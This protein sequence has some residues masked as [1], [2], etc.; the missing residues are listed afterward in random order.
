MNSSPIASY[1]IYRLTKKC[2][3]E[4]EGID[5]GHSVCLK[6]KSLY[7]NK[8]SEN[9]SLGFLEVLKL[10][11]RNWI[12]LKKENKSNK[13]YSKDVFGVIEHL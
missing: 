5:N 11:K 7:S 13:F 8:V 12:L 6:Y 4:I 2:R 1:K 10:K 9:L 3:R